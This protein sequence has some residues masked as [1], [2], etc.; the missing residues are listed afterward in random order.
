MYEQ[1]LWTDIQPTS[2]KAKL[3]GWVFCCFALTGGLKVPQW[4]SIMHT[5]TESK[6]GT[7]KNR[8]FCLNMVADASWV[9]HF[10]INQIMYF[11]ALKP[12]YGR[13]SVGYA[14]MRVDAFFPHSLLRYGWLWVEDNLFYFG[15]SHVCFI[16]RMLCHRA[17]VP[18]SNFVMYDKKSFE[19]HKDRIHVC[20]KLASM[21]FAGLIMIN[22]ETS[23]I[24]SFQLPL[25]VFLGENM[26]VSTQWPLKCA[27][28]LQGFAWYRDL[29]AHWSYLHYVSFLT[30]ASLNSNNLLHSSVCTNLRLD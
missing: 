4:W 24:R 16:P 17:L 5:I 20:L 23:F 30:G 12:Q 1:N 7:N 29:E 28:H 19:R 27:P 21:G 9:V 3:N 6:N 11:M 25:D 14:V 10:Q 26:L 15:I 22:M 18:T 2:P 13:P 8:L